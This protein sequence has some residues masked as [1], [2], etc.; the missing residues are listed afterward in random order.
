[1]E[2]IPSQLVP[3]S[4]VY[5]HFSSVPLPDTEEDRAS[6]PL[7]APAAVGVAGLPGFVRNDAVASSSV[8]PLS[9]YTL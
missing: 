2:E 6:L 5:C 3:P 1:M 7:P 8:Q 9:P 4:F